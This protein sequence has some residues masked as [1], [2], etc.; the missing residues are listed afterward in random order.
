MRIPVEECTTPGKPSPEH[1][2][3]HDKGREE[4]RPRFK[5]R[6][7]ENRR[8]RSRSRE[9]ENQEVVAEIRTIFGGFTGGGDSH[10][11]RK[12]YA[13]QAKVPE[14]YNIERPLKIR[15]KQSLTIGF[16]DQDYEG[17][18][19]PHSD[20][21]VVTFIIANH[22]V[23]RILV[24]TG[25]LADLL[26]WPAFEKLKIDRDRIAPVGF[27]LMG[28]AGEQMH[29]VGSIELPLTPGSVP[30]QATIMVKFLLVDRP[31]AYNAIIGSHNFNTVGSHDRLINKRLRP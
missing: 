20:T 23:H 25:S 19:W 28:F 30:N 15:R 31:L 27:P 17:I 10:T 29:L 8:S 12:A 22:N 7:R 11:S 18:I 24:D 16:S 21:L 14:V 4:D 1:P 26:Y 6:A 13:R 5:E 9:P 3:H 2:W